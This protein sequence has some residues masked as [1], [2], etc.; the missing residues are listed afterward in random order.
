MTARIQ[1]AQNPSAEASKLLDGTVKAFGKKLNILATM[2]N[3]TSTI[4]T[5]LAAQGAVNAHSTLPAP[6]REQLAVAV[7]GANGCDYCAS[8]HTTLG[9]HQK[10]DE[11]E[12]AQN[13]QAKSGDAKTQAALTFARKIVDARGH[14]VAEAVRDAGYSD[15][16]LLDILTVTCVNIFTNYFNELAGTEIDFPLVSTAETKKAA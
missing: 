12:L 4:A 10:L 5:Y 11:A 7:A 16:E 2:A 15:A 8:A 14:V 13:L 9:K 6:L 3:S 1:P